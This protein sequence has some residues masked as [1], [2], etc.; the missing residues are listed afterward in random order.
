[1]FL[2]FSIKLQIRLRRFSCGQRS[3][4]FCSFSSKN[5]LYIKNIT[6]I[7]VL[8]LIGSLKLIPFIASYLKQ[9]VDLF[10][11]QTFLIMNLEHSTVSYFGIRKVLHVCFSTSLSITQYCGSNPGPRLVLF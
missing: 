4:P 6:D 11:R 5:R 9:K 1:M 3:Q 7:D 2:Y 8:N 10:L